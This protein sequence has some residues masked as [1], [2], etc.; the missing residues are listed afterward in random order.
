MKHQKKNLHILENHLHVRDQLVS[1]LENL[2]E[3]CHTLSLSI[4]QPILR[5]MIEVVT[6]ELIDD[7][8][9]GFSVSMR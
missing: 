8:P 9:G 3:R 7:T 6:P 4:V 1:K 2:R 5:G